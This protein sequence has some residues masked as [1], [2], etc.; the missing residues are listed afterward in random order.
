[1]EAALRTRGWRV[2][3]AEMY[4]WNASWAG[5]A[6]R[7]FFFPSDLVA[8]L[9][10]LSWAKVGLHRRTAEKWRQRWAEVQPT[11]AP[12]LRYQGYDVAPLIE[13]LVAREFTWH[14]PRLELMVRI[15]RRLLGL[16]QP[17]LLYIN[18]AYGESQMTAIIAAKLLGIPTVEQQHG[19]IGRNHLAYLVPQRLDV[20]A[21]FPLCDRMF[22]WGE[23]TRRFLLEAGVYRPG[24]VDVVGFPRADML[25]RKL[26][27]RPET[28]ARLGIPAAAQVVLY[29]SND[30]AGD[31][32]GEIL[33]SIQRVPSP[34]LHWLVKLHPREKTRLLW[35]AAI[36]E[37]GLQTTQVL[38]G[39]FD[40]YA[41]LNAC[42]LHVSFASTT[43]IEAAILSK[44][45]LGLDVAHVTDP[46]G[47]AEA[48]A[49]LPV[50]PGELGSAVRNLL[51]NPAQRA[52]LLEIQKAF[53][54]D[55]CLHD[56]KAVERAVS[57]I[58]AIVR[59]PT[60][61]TGDGTD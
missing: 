28:R 5:L 9:S 32:R 42:D 60:G 41:L 27:P 45:N 51:A 44:P 22:V 1:V 52:R 58:E 19:L 12:H 33:D 26:P 16:W 50:P 20:E 31:Q 47:Y 49:F 40:F 4:G 13:P 37:R 36:E 55:W 8:L 61:R 56:G 30:F 43:L 21:R 15:W 17:R 23:Y 34:N 3:V 29:T 2:A 39:E 10:S 14:A 48:N 46:G 25:L 6:A 59:Q 38:E 53:A 7:G 54:E 35:A 18:N 11:L 24:Q 57:L